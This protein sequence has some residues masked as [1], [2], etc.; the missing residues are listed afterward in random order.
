MT[1]T[2]FHVLENRGKEFKACGFVRDYPFTNDTSVPLDWSE[3]CRQSE[4]VPMGFSL[5]VGGIAP[6]LAVYAFGKEPVV[7]IDVNPKV[8]SVGK[9]IWRTIAASKSVRDAKAIVEE[10][11][12]EAYT[13]KHIIGQDFIGRAK[14]STLFKKEVRR[15]GE[16]HWTNADVFDLIK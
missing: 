9:Y 15:M 2:V 11:L 4:K 3:S 13:E 5:I 6:A 16:S 8:T 14:F 12:H 10:T 7:N 1:R